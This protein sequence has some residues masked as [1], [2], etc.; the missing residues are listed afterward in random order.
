[1][2]MTDRG[3]GRGA[4]VP[5]AF[6]L[7]LAILALPPQGSARAGGLRCSIGEVVVENLAAGHSW[8]LRSLANL[9]LVLTNSG[10]DSAIVRVDP[11][12]PGPDQLRHNAEPVGAASWGYAVPDSFALA[13]HETKLVDLG[14]RIPNDTTLCGRTFQI[15]FWSHTLATPGNLLAFGLDSR[16]IFSVAR[17]E[18]AN[19]T[20]GAGDLAIMLAPTE[21]RLPPAAPGRVYQLD[22]PLRAPLIVRNTSSEPRTVEVNAIRA[23][24]SESRL[25]AGYGELLD[26]AKV[27]LTPQRF[28]LAPGEERRITGSV[29]FPAGVHAPKTPLMCVVSASAVDRPVLTRIYARIVAEAR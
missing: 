25:P 9:P 4:G 15:M 1:M 8:S 26:A 29:R 17:P 22:D 23:R 19:L 20:E 21:I 14:L 16:V 7:A 3:T 12:V 18:S 13:P 24:D 28:T 27:T 5:S 2:M 10:D 6:V 11:H